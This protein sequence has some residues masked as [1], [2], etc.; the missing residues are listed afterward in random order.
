MLSKAN[1]YS[2]VFINEMVSNANVE[3]VVKPP[4]NPV[5]NNALVFA[6]K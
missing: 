5:N 3:N 1:L 2:P 6:E 4:K